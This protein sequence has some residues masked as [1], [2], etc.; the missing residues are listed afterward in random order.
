MSEIPV[1]LGNSTRAVNGSEEVGH[2]RIRVL[3]IYPN[4]RGTTML[5]PAMGLLSAVL[6]ERGHEVELF[7]TTFY[8]SVD[9]YSESTDNVVGGP[10]SLV[11]E[12]LVD[13][14]VGA[15]HG[16]DLTDMKRINR[17]MVRAYEMPEEVTLRSTS[18]FDDLLNQ[19]NEFQP[20]LLAMSCTEDM[21]N[22]GIQLLDHVRKH[23]KVLTILGGVF[24]T[25]APEFV[26]S[27]DAV[28]IVCK[29]EGEDALREL[30]DRLASDQLFDDIPNLWVK[31]A[32]GE[33]RENPIQ[34]VDMNA[35]PLIDME[36]FEEARYYR[37]MAGRV[38]KMFPVETHRGCPYKCAFCNSPSQMKLYRDEA[39]ENY[40]RRNSF[41]HIE[42]ELLFYKE[43]MGAQYLYFWADTFFSWKPG[44]FEEFAKMYEKIG[45]PFW[46]QTRVETVELER[47]QLLKETGCARMSFG[48]E[49]GNEEFRA[50]W[51]KRRMSNEM[52][53]EN[54]A[55]M[56][57]VGIPFSV[58]N[59]MGFPHETREL[60][61]DT[62][63]LN[64]RFECADRNAFMFTPFTGTP[65][66]DECNR[67]GF[68][69]PEQVVQSV[70][71]DGTP[72]DM[73]QFPRAEVQG[74]IKTFNMYV[75]F[76]E[77]RWPEIRE[78]EPDTP[79]ANE[80]YEALKSE[81]VDLFWSEEPTASFEEAALV[82]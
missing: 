51:L 41:E 81:F 3:L 40:L 24:P 54:F 42:R 56:N 60:A 78:A 21:W 38:W 53:V 74:L 39:G 47:L 22:L 2:S 67:L 13:D 20:D 48:L 12:P 73:P 26:L 61:F 50:T 69:D 65:L 31:L 71:T 23:R 68:T 55:I 18:P 80:R 45:L 14:E 34:M 35:N 4:G 1:R 57:E 30:C 36:I 6:K 9:D 5:P 77:S 66:R 7:D 17:L 11:G 37:P 46:C 27:H 63:K 79:E 70:N 44:E 75:N 59:I 58:N 33:I 49:H 64:R 19:V 28:D 15:V 25:F 29:G 52:I 72:L 32:S 82:L 16:S 43:E 8:A 10:T 62:V 76:D